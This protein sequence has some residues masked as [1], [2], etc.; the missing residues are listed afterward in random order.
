MARENAFEQ[1]HWPL[2]Q[3]LG[4]QRVIGVRERADGDL[5]GFVPWDVVKVDKNAH[6]LGDSDARMRVVELNGCPFRERVDATECTGVPM[7][8]VLQRGRNEEVF[9]PQT[10]FS[11][12]LRIIAWI[13][14]L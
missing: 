13:K 10:Q 6:Q 5:P 12:R 9:L 1:R 3:C 7:D 11:P 2:L 14:N 4:Q 8:K